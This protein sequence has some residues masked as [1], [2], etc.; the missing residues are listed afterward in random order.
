MATG[1]GGGVATGSD[2]RDSS[3]DDYGPMSDPA[4]RTHDSESKLGQHWTPGADGSYSPV[5][6]PAGDTPA[7]AGGT[8]VP[9]YAMKD[10]PPTFAE[11]SPAQPSADHP[12]E[13]Q[14]VMGSL[15][16]TG[17]TAGPE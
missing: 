17:R 13:G 3:G 5:D 7:M 6:H 9:D 15:A 8:N 16:G 12:A 14:Q 10:T 2:P 1:N 11:D 4:G